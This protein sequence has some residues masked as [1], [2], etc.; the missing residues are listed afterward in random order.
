[1][2]SDTVVTTTVTE[3]MVVGTDIEAEVVGLVPGSVEFSTVEL[4]VSGV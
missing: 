4:K 1:M 3:P 2:I